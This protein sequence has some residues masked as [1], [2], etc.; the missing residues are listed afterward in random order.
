MSLKKV[1]RNRA[2][3]GEYRI[4]QYE[5]IKTGMLYHFR[6]YFYRV[7]YYFYQGSMLKLQYVILFNL[8]YVVIEQKGKSP[9]HAEQLYILKN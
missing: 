9:W 1:Q 7:F 3:E 6:G 4:Q 2:F 8:E 5:Q